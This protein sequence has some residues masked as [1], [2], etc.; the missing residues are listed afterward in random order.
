MLLCSGMMNAYAQITSGTKVKACFFTLGAFGEKA[1]AEM[2]EVWAVKAPWEHGSQPQI[3]INF[4]FY[5]LLCLK[6]QVRI[7]FSGISLFLDLFLH[8]YTI[9]RW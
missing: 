9:T 3:L 2:C 4:N 8:T 6:S 1:F 7:S 5:L